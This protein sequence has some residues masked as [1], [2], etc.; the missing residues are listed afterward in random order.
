L[1]NVPQPSTTSSGQPPPVEGQS[2]TRRAF[3]LSLLG[4]LVGITAAT[5]VY[6]VLAYLSPR[7]SAAGG[8][9]LL[10]VNGRPIPISSIGRNASIIGTGVDGETTIVVRQGGELRAFSAACTHL[11]C[12]VKWNAGT[13]EFLCPCH[14]GKFDA[15]GMNIFGPPPSPLKRFRPYATPEGYIGLEVFAT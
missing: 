5:F 8:N 6:P 11:G 10:G 2:P 4:T 13:A 9:L 1:E 14:G 12:L 15:K 3:L 7:K